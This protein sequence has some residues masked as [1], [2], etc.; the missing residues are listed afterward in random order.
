MVWTR[1]PIKLLI[2]NSRFVEGYVKKY[3]MWRLDLIKYLFFKLAIFTVAP[4]VV[5]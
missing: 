2:I 4:L 3:I 5:L 1:Y